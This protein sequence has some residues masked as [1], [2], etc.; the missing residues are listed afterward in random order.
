MKSFKIVEIKMQNENNYIILDLIDGVIINNEVS[1]DSWIV[2]VATSEDFKDILEEFIGTEVTL[3][4]RITR[5]SNTPALFHGK[6]MEMN[7]ISVGLSLIFIGDI[8]QQGPHYAEELLEKLMQENYEGE[9][10]LNEFKTR[11]ESKEDIKTS[12]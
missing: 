3:L 7:N 4:I 11:M 10:L 9:A 2:E 6:L 12:D 5:A 8:I 1:K